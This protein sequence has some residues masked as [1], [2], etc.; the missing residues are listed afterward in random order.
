MVDKVEARK[1]LSNALAIEA[2]LENLLIKYPKA[3]DLQ[4]A[5]KNELRNTQKR[6]TGIELL[7]K[8]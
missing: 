7:L 4:Q 6:I 8:T 5:V 2:L 1:N 3:L